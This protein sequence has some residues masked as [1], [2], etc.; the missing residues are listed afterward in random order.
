M[1]KIVYLQTNEEIAKSFQEEFIKNE[2]EMMIVKSGEEALDLISKEKV[3]LLLLDINIPD[4]RFRKLVDRIRAIS[5][6]VIINVC[7]DVLDPLMITK[8]SNRHSVHKIY[9]APWDVDEIIEEVKESIEIAVI[10]EQVNIREEKISSEIDDLKSTIDSLKNTLKKQQ[11]SYKKFVGLTDCFIDALK[12]EDT[13]DSEANKKIEFAK[14]IYKGILRLQTTGSFD[15]DKFED[16]IKR[17][18]CEMKGISSGFEIGTIESCLFAGQSRAYAQNIRF[19]IFIIARLYAE[20]YE[21]FSM[22]VLSH[23]ITTKDAAFNIEVNIK[24]SMKWGDV[25]VFDEYSTFVEK[26]LESMTGD[27]KIIVT[28]EDISYNCEFP[29]SRE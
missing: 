28:G 24:S 3:L 7:I 14:D 17:D 19:C 16:E 26:I 8:L 27:R 18:L 25:M 20:F 22:S 12:E 15:I 2:I 23:Y 4:M 1:H 5:P 29:V 10:N 13:T 11:H 9:V 6:Q 21:A